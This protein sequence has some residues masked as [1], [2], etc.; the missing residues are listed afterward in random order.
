[1]TAAATEDP[2]ASGSEISGILQATGSNE[3]LP[4]TSQLESDL[5]SNGWSEANADAAAPHYEYTTTF[6]PESD[7]VH[8]LQRVG[9]L[10][11]ALP[12]GLAG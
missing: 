7:P 2:T 4:D 3:G 1:V 8:R 10:L 11:R 6:V 5:V 12:G 9:R